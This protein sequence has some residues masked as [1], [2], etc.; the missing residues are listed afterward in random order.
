MSGAAAELGTQ[1][2]L[3]SWQK[4]AVV[5][6]WHRRRSHRRVSFV[7]LEQPHMMVV[8]VALGVLLRLEKTLADLLKEGIAVAEERVDRLG[9]SY[10]RSVRQ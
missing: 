1:H 6:W 3:W 4:A 2:T 7:R 10:S 8:V 5:H 9:L